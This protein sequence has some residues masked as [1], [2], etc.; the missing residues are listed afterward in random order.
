MTAAEGSKRLQEMT[1]IVPGVDVT[2][3]WLTPSSR[4]ATYFCEGEIQAWYT[5]PGAKS[6][7]AVQM[8]RRRN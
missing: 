6:R 2:L 1:R 8:N 4:L 7:V 5:A 3:V